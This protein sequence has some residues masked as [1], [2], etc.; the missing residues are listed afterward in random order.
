MRFNVWQQILSGGAKNLIH[1]PPIAVD[2]GAGSLKVLQI[3]P[4][5][6]PSLVSAACLETPEG[7]LNDPV[8]RLSFQLDALPDLVRAAEFKGRRAVCALPAAV[9]YCKHMQFQQEPGVPLTTMI[10]N[11]VP[12]Q[13]KC[14]ANALVFKH[15][16]VGPVA[17]TNKTEVIC[18]AAAREMVERFMGALKLSKLEPVGMHS[19]FIAALR[20][21]DSMNRAEGEKSAKSQTTLYLDVGV[22]CTKVAI[23]HGRDLVFARTIDLGGRHL[24]AV[25][26][27]QLKVNASQA[28]AQRLAMT[29]LC[30]AA[31]PT[32]AS[33]E[34]LSGRLA[35]LAAPAPAGT[36]AVA[37]FG[38]AGPRSLGTKSTAPD[39][40]NLQEPLEILTDEVSMCLR[41]H[42]SVF[43]DRRVDRAIFLGGESRHLGLCQHIAR[44]LRLPA[45]V[46]DPM[47]RVVRTGDEPTVGV[48]FAESQPGWTVALGLCLCP[49]DL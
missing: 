23:A 22:G 44:T 11:A 39:V 27:K 10:R 49:T 38:A 42:E 5:D 3:A 30:A 37:G 13:L 20:A 36:V 43:P 1:A 12:L 9:T 8:K 24:D 7:L 48:S 25:L 46:A 31:L 17:R 2:F 32:P 35:V 16:E 14:D 41:Y 15:V 26:A 18:M 29:Q 45:Q 6:P 33:P 34:G 19:E 40:G 28:R 4:G 47:A 21:F